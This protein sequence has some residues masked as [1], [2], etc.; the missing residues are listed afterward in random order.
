MRILVLALTLLA[1]ALFIWQFL[2]V[3]GKRAHVA[4]GM[5]IGL[6]SILIV[7]INTVSV[8]TKR[9]L[10]WD[11]VFIIHTI[12]GSVFFSGL[13][14]T[15]ALGFLTMRQEVPKSWHRLSAN[16]TGI[17]FF[18]TLIAAAAIRFFR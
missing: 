16:I 9:G 2:G 5:A 11:A 10:T 12:L 1:V 13:L 4:R 6:L 17:F 3:K 8:S 14:I 18:L 15:C 7:V